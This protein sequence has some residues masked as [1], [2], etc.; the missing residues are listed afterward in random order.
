VEATIQQ[1]KTKNAGR[2]LDA[3]IAFSMDCGKRAEEK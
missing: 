2:K 1:E 3:Y